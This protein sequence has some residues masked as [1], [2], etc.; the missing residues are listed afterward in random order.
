MVRKT[1]SMLGALIL[2]S[3]PFI[4]AAS[5]QSVCG[6]HQLVAEKLKQS[7]DEQ[8]TGA[9]LSHNGGMIE[10][11]SSPDGTWTIVL[12]RPDGISCLMASGE[13]WE[14]MAPSIIEFES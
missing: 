2:L 11:Y 10:V 12:T 1:I 13:L 5:A 14:S 3:I 6:T 7:Y 8:L 9:G 4:P